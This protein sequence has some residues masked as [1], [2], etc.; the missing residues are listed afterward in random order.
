[1]DGPGGPDWPQQEPLDQ[2]WDDL[3]RTGPARSRDETTEELKRSLGIGVPRVRYQ[4]GLPDVSG[5]AEE[6]G[7]G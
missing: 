4:P 5:L 7:L 3:L 2:G 1:M 6:L